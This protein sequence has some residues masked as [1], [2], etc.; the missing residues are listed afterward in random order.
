MY[1][2]QQYLSDRST[3][4][5]LNAS[6]KKKKKTT[7]TTTYIVVRDNLR[8]H[9]VLV[10]IYRQQLLKMDVL[11]QV[12]ISPNKTSVMEEFIFFILCYHSQYFSN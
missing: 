9:M 10:V 5:L 1:E 11:F 8:Q 4:S 6:R 3:I 7:N 2:K 12:W